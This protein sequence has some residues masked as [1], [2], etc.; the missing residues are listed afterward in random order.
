MGV[1]FSELPI[2]ES[3]NVDPSID[4]IAVLDKSDMMVKQVIL[5]HAADSAKWGQATEDEWGHV[6]TSTEYDHP[7]ETPTGGYDPSL[8]ASQNGLYRAWYDVITE[9]KRTWIGRKNEWEILP[10]DE[11]NK[12]KIVCFTDV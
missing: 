7:V 9:C 1:R 10:T 2:L 5:N 4:T 3:E 11:K 6:R 8:V 12:Y